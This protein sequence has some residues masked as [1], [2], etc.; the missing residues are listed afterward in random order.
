VVQRVRTTKA[1]RT[2]V[3]RL[4]DKPLHFGEFGVGRLFAD[5]GIF[6]HYSCA[7]GRM[8]DQHAEVPVRA[9]PTQYRHVFGKD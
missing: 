5:R 6:A 8:P 3:H 1:D 2:L 9:A 7:H 4:A